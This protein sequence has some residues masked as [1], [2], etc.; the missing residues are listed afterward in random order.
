MSNPWGERCSKAP[1][2]IC[3]IMLHS[4]NLFEIIFGLLILTKI[5]QLNRSSGSEQEPPITYKYP[6]LHPDLSRSPSTSL[7][8]I[9]KLK[10]VQAPGIYHKESI[11]VMTWGLNAMYLRIYLTQVSFNCKE[12]KWPWKIWKAFF[13]PLKLWKSFM[14][15][16]F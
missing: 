11:H 2:L 6:Q 9:P 8:M 4:Y 7:C 15:K 10:F 13:S 1:L 3:S 12:E 16:T 14:N 5:L